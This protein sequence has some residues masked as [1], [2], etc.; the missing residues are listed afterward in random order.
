VLL[1]IAYQKEKI[2]NAICFFANEH[3][4]RT[5]KELF[6]TFLYK[7][8]AFLDFESLSE[9]GVPIL[10]LHYLAL[11][12]GP[13]PQEIYRNNQYKTSD[14]YEFKGINGKTII[15]PK[16]K[17]DLDY[18]S[19]YELEKMERLVEIFAQTTLTSAH[20]SEASHDEIKAWK[21]ARKLNPNKEIDY[22]LQ[23]D[24]DLLEK[25]EKDL[26]PAEENFIIYSSLHYSK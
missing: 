26:S 18:F 19:E 20:I 23:F 13:V 1:F 24:S 8:L 11:E 25:K 6:Q 5:R 4:R 12:R 15:I 9:T 2:E 17:P 3:K 14:C 7:Y 22:L 10:G 21:R 16:K